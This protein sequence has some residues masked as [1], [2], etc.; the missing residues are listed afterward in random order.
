M[1]LLPLRSPL[2]RFRY[3]PAAPPHGLGPHRWRLWD[4]SG[5]NREGQ[6]ALPEQ[7]CGDGT[8]AWAWKRISLHIPSCVSQTQFIPSHHNP[9]QRTKHLDN[10]MHLFDNLS[11]QLYTIAIVMCHFSKELCPWHIQIATHSAFKM[12]LSKWKAIR[13]VTHRRL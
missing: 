2:S 9:S 12:S 3:A 8:I 10:V 4:P 1:N 11:E 6:L 13:I 5:S 7:H